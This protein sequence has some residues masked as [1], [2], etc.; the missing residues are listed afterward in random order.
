MTIPRIL[1]TIMLN[2]LG[3]RPLPDLW[4]CQ[5]SDFSKK[6]DFFAW[7]KAVNG[8]LKHDHSKNLENHNAKYVFPLCF[9]VFYDPAPAQGSPDDFYGFS[10]GSGIAHKRWFS[11]DIAY[12]YRFG[13]NVG[14]SVLKDWDFS[15]DVYE[16]AVYTSVI[17]YF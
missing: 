7:E 10:I 17:F 15:Q 4:G 14:S 11:F 16:H 1:K 8:I 5:K 3:L 12:Q 9:G 13:N 6:S 2:F